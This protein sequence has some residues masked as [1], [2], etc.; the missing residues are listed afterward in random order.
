MWCSTRLSSRSS[1]VYPLHKLSASCFK[2]CNTIQCILFG[3]DTTVYISGRNEPV[4]CQLIANDLA[5][6]TDW[7]HANKLSLN[8]FKTNFMKVGK[9]SQT[10][11]YD[12]HL[13]NNSITKISSAKCLGI[14]IYDEL[15]WSE[16]INHITKKIAS[17]SYAIYSVKRFL[18]MNNMKLLY[19]SLINSH[20]SYGTMC[21]VEHI[22]I[23]CASQCRL[24]KLEISQKKCIRN[25][26][27]KKYNEHTSP[28]FK[29]LNILKLQDISR[30]QLGTFMYNF[31]HS[32]LP[33]P[34]VTLFPQNADIHG[35]SMR[36]SRN[37]HQGP[38]CGMSC[39]CQPDQS[40]RFMR[41]RVV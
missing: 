18:S 17:R 8:V 2:A 41:L 4:L 23:H 25:I 15:G 37:P 5:S 33:P 34:L 39:P 27:N 40:T 16:H 11:E 21:T 13:S 12:L 30:F 19:H 32:E 9:G 36:Q 24:R 35:H 3:D 31:A 10:S 1:P 28:L 26:C 38:N 29:K 7:F 14:I 20:F 6:L 22:L